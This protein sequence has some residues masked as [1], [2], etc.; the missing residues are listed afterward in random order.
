M[1]NF[2]PSL[3]LFFRELVVTNRPKKKKIFAFAQTELLLIRKERLEIVRT[4]LAKAGSM[5]SS[6][7]VNHDCSYI[8]KDEGE[9]RPSAKK[10]QGR[11][12]EQNVPSGRQL[13]D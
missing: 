11:E 4:G 6:P 9:E 10:R 2:K 1:A 3:A 8:T 12:V 13:V 7:K 5:H